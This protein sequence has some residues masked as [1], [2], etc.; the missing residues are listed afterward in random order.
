MWAQ[1][2]FDEEVVGPA[3]QMTI[4]SNNY[5]RQSVFNPASDLTSPQIN[6]FL[7]P[8]NS[9]DVRACWQ[10]VQRRAEDLGYTDY[11][12]SYKRFKALATECGKI[13]TG[14]AKEAIT[15]LNG[16]M[17]GLYKNARREIYGTKGRK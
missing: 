16:E 7:R 4:D 6:Q 10:E 12:C 8:D 14:S 11:H 13:T 17:V 3:C 2:R 15:V 1:S 5:N 9:V